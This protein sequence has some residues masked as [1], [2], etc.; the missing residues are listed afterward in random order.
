MHPVWLLNSFRGA[1]TQAYLGIKRHFEEMNNAFFRKMDV[2]GSHNILYF[3]L[4]LCLPFGFEQCYH[5]VWNLWSGFIAIEFQ[6]I[7]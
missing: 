2:K 6:L 3:I 1:H 7:K 5:P 4:A